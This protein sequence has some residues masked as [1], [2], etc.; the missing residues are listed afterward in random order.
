M[1]QIIRDLAKVKLGKRPSERQEE[2]M[3]AFMHA[4]HAY[5]NQNLVGT[6][7]GVMNAYTDYATHLPP[8]SKALDG[9]Q[10]RFEAVSFSNREQTRML[11]IVSKEHNCPICGTDRTHGHGTTPCPPTEE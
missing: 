10:D 9:A 11:A 5:D 1:E 4:Y 7:W 3:E 6:A 2:N 8:S